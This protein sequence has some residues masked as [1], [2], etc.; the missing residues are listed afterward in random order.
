MGDTHDVRGYL[1][2]RQ[3]RQPDAWVSLADIRSALGLEWE[4]A[5][6]A[7]QALADHGEA[8]L[9]GGFP[10]RPVRQD[11]TLVRLTEKG[12][13]AKPTDPTAR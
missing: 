4:T 2:E 1:A 6:R 10:L 8:E 11:F 9:M 12:I 13:A 5:A 3:R 7:C